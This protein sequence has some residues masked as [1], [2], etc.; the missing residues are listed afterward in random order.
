MRN[1]RPAAA[2]MVAVAAAAAV[3]IAVAAAEVAGIVT[4]TELAG[5]LPK[6]P[7]SDGG[8]FSSCDR[9]SPAL[10][11]NAAGRLLGRF[12]RA[13]ER[14]NPHLASVMWKVADQHHDRQCRRLA[15]LHLI[16]FAL[17]GVPAGP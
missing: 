14:E 8:F 17:Q 6:P 9:F 11:L 3:E 5:T 1:A 10:R 12:R 13:A 15:V 2:V 4:G 16:Q 7:S